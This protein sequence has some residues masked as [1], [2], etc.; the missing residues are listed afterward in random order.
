[1]GDAPVA[2]HG[3]RRLRHLPAAHRAGRA[4]PRTAASSPQ[5]RELLDWCMDDAPR[6]LRHRSSP[7]RRRCCAAASSPTRSSRRSSARVAVADPD[8][9]LHARHGAV[10]GR[11]RARPPSASTGSCSSASRTAPRRA[12]RSARCCSPSAATRMPP[13]EAAVLSGRRSACRRSPA[14]P[15]CSAG[16]PPATS[17]A[18]GPRARRAVPSGAPGGRARAVR[19]LGSSW[20]AG[21][22]A[23]TARCPPR[24]R[25]CS[26]SML[27]ALL[28]VHDFDA[29]RVA[30]R[31]CSRAASC[32]SA[33]SAN[34]LPA[35][36]CA[37][38][39]CPPRPSSGWRCAPSSPMPRALP[40]AGAGR[41]RPRFARG[42]GELRR[43]PRSSSIPA[44]L[45]A[46][47]LPVRAL[48]RGRRLAKTRTEE[49]GDVRRSQ[50]FSGCARLRQL[51]SKP[52][53]VIRAA[54]PGQGA[55]L[56][57]EEMRTDEP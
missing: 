32:P 18:L 30:G 44:A 35:S 8:R 21:E 7:T 47:A 56:P 15:S 49:I 36:T 25:R 2:L 11:R 4:A 50:V 12:S 24:R 22:P 39:S 31:R 17:P 14:A 20:P 52:Q 40:R 3:D 55:S 28:R 5:A 34:C 57:R 27:E 41:R 16:S 23:P 48:R 45:E 37:A 53:S 19:R 43:A 6:L 33:S 54:T 1:M 9:A 51:K 42:R 46:R 13:S 38:A 29:L 26:G 10:R